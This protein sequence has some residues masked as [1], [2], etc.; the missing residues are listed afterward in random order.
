MSNLKS[1]ELVRQT[2]S[3]LQGEIKVTS[4]VRLPRQVLLGA[5]H[6]QAYLRSSRETDAFRTVAEIYG[7]S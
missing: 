6:L 2:R 4:A 7:A 3:R 1:E 5:H